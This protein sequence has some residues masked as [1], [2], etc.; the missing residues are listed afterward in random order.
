MRP[1][2]NEAA[3]LV[4][5]TS[6]DMDGDVSRLSANIGGY[7]NTMGAHFGRLGDQAI[8]AGQV[9]HSDFSS[10]VYDESMSRLADWTV[11]TGQSLIHMGEDAA[12]AAGGVVAVRSAVAAVGAAALEAAGPAAAVGVAL[13]GVYEAARLVISTASGIAQWA[14]NMSGAAEVARLFSEEGTRAAEAHRALA[15][16]FGGEADSFT[17]VQQVAQDYQVTQDQA[18]AA[19][20]RMI[21]VLDP[22]NKSTEAARQV[23]KDYGVTSTEASAALDEF[24]RRL[25][26]T[27]DGTA[28]THDVMAVLG[29][30]GV[31][32]LKGVADGA[33]QISHAMTDADRISAATAASIEASKNKIATAPHIS[34]LGQLGDWAGGVVDRFSEMSTRSEQFKAEQ[35]A[36]M[37]E[38]S[39][40]WREW[41]GDVTST[42]DAISRVGQGLGDYFAV[43]TQGLPEFQQFVGI[44]KPAVPAAAQDNRPAAPP[45][46]DAAG[47]ADDGDDDPATNDGQVLSQLEQQ[48][49]RKLLLKENWLRED[50]AL[51]VSFWQQRLADERADGLEENSTLMGLLNDRLNQAERAQ[52]RYLKNQ[53]DASARQA[54]Q[55][56]RDA[57][58][59]ADEQSSAHLRGLQIATNAAVRGSQERIQA[60]QAEVDF[61][62]GAWGELSSQYRDAMQRMSEAARERDRQAQE[63][64]RIRADADQKINDLGLQAERSRLDAEVAAGKISEGQKADQLRD[65]TEGAQIAALQRLDSEISS[66]QQGTKAWEEATQR[67][68]VLVAEQQ[69]EME[70]ISLQAV[71]ADRRAAQQTAQAWQGAFQ[72]ASRALDSWVQNA[73]RGGQTIGQSALSAAGTMAS[74][75]IGSL[76]RM[77]AQLG[78]FEVAQALGWTR[79]AS[80]MQADIQK[81]SLSWLLGEQQKTAAT[82]AGTSAR[83]AAASAENST[84]LGR[85]IGQVASWLGIE[86]SKTSATTAATATRATIDEADQVARSTTGYIAA[87]GQIAQLAPVAAA[88]AFAAT[89]AIPIVGPE[90]A[91]GAAA[92]AEGAVMSLAATVPV[93]SASGGWGDVP[94]DEAPTF[95]HKREMVLP[96]YLASPLRDLVTGRGGFALPASFATSVNDNVSAA[97]S[98]MGGGQTVVNHNETHNWSLSALDGR[99][100]Q[101]WLRNGGGDQIVAHVQNKRRN[102]GAL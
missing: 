16:E 73:V 98:A 100:T 6:A 19:I 15:L 31:A 89:A 38:I 18:T 20:R 17:R 95:L 78:A 52:A 22:A 90:L 5:G 85:V 50:H 102:F 29:S 32:W 48:L 35:T 70:R 64:S 4:E 21:E 45:H 56:A 53:A 68:R 62:R 80:G 46:E 59:A 81:G 40:A 14:S 47:G 74:S 23:L 63:I 24:A 69:V 8:S 25:R 51:E 28:K 76:L 96:A 12:I 93:F 2:L 71:E 86:T 101:T 92:A 77:T 55:D 72:P 26:E 88:G 75:Y 82:A 57:E 1:D 36:A 66:L 99:S 94:H 97:A 41:R 60:A 37:A 83:T 58:R 34:W 33:G 49:Q 91:P 10:Q 3:G 13:V 65:L 44:Q 43:L 87:V 79:M 84:W 61:A 30:D 42:G 11:D 54:D 7:V 9:I 27:Q 67:R 39:T